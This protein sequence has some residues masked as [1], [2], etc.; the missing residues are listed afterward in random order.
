MS[1]EF[2]TIFCMLLNLWVAKHLQK[3]LKFYDRKCQPGSNRL[4]K[5]I[6]NYIPENLPKYKQV[7]NPF[8]LVEDFL[9]EFINQKLF[10]RNT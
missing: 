10:G 3:K 2:Y 9:H 6:D 7:Q 4:V 8:S 5:K 1:T